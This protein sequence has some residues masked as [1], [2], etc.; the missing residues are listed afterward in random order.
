MGNQ[1]GYILG[2]I[3]LWRMR[4]DELRAAAEMLEDGSRRQALLN[5]ATG[6]DELTNA[7]EANR[8]RAMT[9]QRLGNDT[10]RL[11][12]ESKQ[13]IAQARRGDKKLRRS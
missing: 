2:Q 11:I 5:M 8:E 3:R 9:L 7:V 6:Y 10:Q 12:E 4:A 1:N 13:I